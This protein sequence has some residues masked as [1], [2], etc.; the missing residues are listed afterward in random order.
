MLFGVSG[1]CSVCRD[2]GDGRAGGGFVDDGFVGAKRGDESLQRKVWAAADAEVVDG[3]GIGS[4]RQTLADLKRAGDLIS[5]W[6][7][8]MKIVDAAERGGKIGERG[9]HSWATLE[10]AIILRKL[11]D[12]RGEIEVLERYLAHCP[13]GW[14]DTKVV[15]RLEKLRI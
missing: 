10:A 8:V 1:W 4:C 3:V 5:A 14:A 6:K 11:K 7:L 9:P 13:P 2:F 15:E 12:T